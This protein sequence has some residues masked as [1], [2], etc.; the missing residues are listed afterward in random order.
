LSVSGVGW[1]VGS[2]G[3][4]WPFSAGRRVGFWQA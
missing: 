2:F 1:V 3:L 4:D